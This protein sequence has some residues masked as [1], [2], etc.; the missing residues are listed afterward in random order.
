MKKIGIG[1]GLL[2][3][4][5]AAGIWMIRVQDVDTDVT[6]E[7]T[8]VGMV[9]NGNKQDLNWGQSHYEAMEKTA[10]KLNLQIFYCEDIPENED[11]RETFE[12]LADQGCEIIIADSIGY[13]KFM[14]EAA[15]KHPEIHYYHST[16][17]QESH[18]LATY[19]GRMYQIRYLC[20]IVAGLQ[21][22][23][24]E[25]GYVAA[26]PNSEVNRGINAFTLG[27][28]SVNPDAT[29]YVSWC[30]SWG[31]DEAAETAT[32]KLLAK[33]DIDVLSMHTN[34]LKALEV[35]QEAGVWSIGCN[36]DNSA[37]YPDTWLTGAVWNWEEF[38]EPR[39]L[40]CLQG[41]FQGK[42]YWLGM[43]SNM[44]SL[45]PLTANV[46]PGTEEI[47][48]EETKKLKSGS[49][50][51]FYGPIRD[52]EGNIRIGDGESMTDTAMW[53]SFDWFVEGVEFCE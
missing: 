43:E 8:R 45:S 49:F 36:M 13:E 6:K 41:K 4:A 1:A 18:N 7:K 31:V 53:N 42:N 19:F 44:V 51:V 21:T 32:R 30:D 11:S 39:I 50:D 48:I 15:E 28:R 29:V 2:L 34:S 35:A 5:I 10:A 26:M 20:G 22:R 24:N 14:L 16:G 37:L 47:I 9:L 3:L 25:I 12:E 40:E 46:A 38:Y 52:R 27:V 17:V 33:H 23:T